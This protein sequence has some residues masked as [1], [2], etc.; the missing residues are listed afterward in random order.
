MSYRIRLEKFIQITHG[1]VI[2][3]FRHVLEQNGLRL[4]FERGINSSEVG[5]CQRIIGM[6]VTQSFVP[7][8]Q[9]QEV[10]HFAGK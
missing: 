4:Q 2:P 6:L 10:G 9:V 3:F 8:F 1:G 7:I 5:K